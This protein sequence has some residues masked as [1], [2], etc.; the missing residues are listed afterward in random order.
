M[1]Y[2]LAFTAFLLWGCV[3]EPGIETTEKPIPIGDELPDA[4][5]LTLK[6]N[7]EIMMNGLTYDFEMVGKAFEETK[8]KKE[9]IVLKTYPETGA[10][11]V[12]LMI[13]KIKELGY[14]KIYVSTI[15]E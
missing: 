15:N 5:V 9:T 7:K 14:Q 8:E 6:P 4:H 12:V 1:R 2:I 3:K 13:D 11:D 10:G